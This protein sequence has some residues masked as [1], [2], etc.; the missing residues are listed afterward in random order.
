MAVIKTRTSNRI[1][2]TFYV[3]QDIGEDGTEFAYDIKD[4]GYTLRICKSDGTQIDMVNLPN[5]REPDKRSASRILA[6]WAVKR[7]GAENTEA[8]VPSE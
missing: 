1:R 3:I 5:T 8:H 6:D 2:F 7:W 4:D